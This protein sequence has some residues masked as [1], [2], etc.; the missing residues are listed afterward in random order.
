MKAAVRRAN[1]KDPEIDIARERR[2]APC[3][4]GQT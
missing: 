4:T 2:D 1:I 3:Y